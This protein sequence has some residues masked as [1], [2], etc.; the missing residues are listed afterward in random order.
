[1]EILPAGVFSLITYFHLF[2]RF[3]SQSGPE[4]DEAAAARLQQ[5]YRGHLTRGMR[6]TLARIKSLDMSHRKIPKSLSVGAVGCLKDG[7]KWEEE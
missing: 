4:R 1:L 5:M 6:A 7:Q 2:V 3:L